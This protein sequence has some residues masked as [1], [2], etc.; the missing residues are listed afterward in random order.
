MLN[1]RPQ[2]KYFFGTGGRLPKIFSFLK[3]EITKTLWEGAG[4]TV[5]SEVNNEKAETL[6]RHTTYQHSNAA[7]MMIF[8]PTKCTGVRESAIVRVKQSFCYICLTNPTQN[9]RGYINGS[10]IPLPPT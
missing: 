3:Q 9:I 5:M 1:H 10:E 7:E 2:A 8:P 4:V 6:H